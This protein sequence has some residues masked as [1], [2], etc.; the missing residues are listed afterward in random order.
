MLIANYRLDQWI[1]GAIAGTRELGLYSVAVAW[2]EG[3]FLLPTALSAVQRPDLVRAKAREA[4][5]LTAR[6]FRMSL[7]ITLFCAS[8]L[9]VA[10][11]ILCVTFFGE[12][13]RGSIDDLRV[14]T[15]GAFG[16]VALKQ[17]GS[18]LTARQRP[19]L[20]SAAISSAFASTVVLDFLLIP[21]YGGLGAAVASAVSYTFGGVVIVAVFLSALGGTARDF[22]PSRGDAHGAWR[23]VMKG[24]RRPAAADAAPDAVLAET[25]DPVEPLTER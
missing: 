17:L 23:L 22:V 10:A 6:L 25:V 8:A 16:I 2:A 24:L 14:L 18:A 21:H 15:A 19:T 12:D 11:P 5:Q 13:F 4:V 7:V 20:A 3:L 9:V 1:L